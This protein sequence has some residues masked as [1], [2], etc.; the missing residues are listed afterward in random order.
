MKMTAPLQRDEEFI[1][2]L[3]INLL[4]E[5]CGEFLANVSPLENKLPKL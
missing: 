1:F 3:L 4:R 5:V 2:Q